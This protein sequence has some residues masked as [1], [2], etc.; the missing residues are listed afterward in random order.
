MHGQDG[1]EDVL[2]RLKEIAN[3]PRRCIDVRAKHDRRS[4]IKYQVCIPDSENSDRTAIPAS[5]LTN[6]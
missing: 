1:L 5:P 2:K 4:A 3:R 6:P